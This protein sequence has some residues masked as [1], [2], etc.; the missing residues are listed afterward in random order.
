MS[1]FMTPKMVRALQ[2]PFVLLV[3]HIIAGEY[4]AALDGYR[5][6]KSRFNV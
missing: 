1:S 3:D 6:F 4:T 5:I 2:L